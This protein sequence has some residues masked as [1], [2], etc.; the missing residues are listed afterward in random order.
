MSTKITKKQ[1]QILQFIELYLEENHTS[2]SYREI[3]SGLGLSSVSAV[4]EHVENLV[5]KGALKKVD[6]TARSLE[7]LD[8]RHTDTVNLFRNRLISS[9]PE[10]TKILLK[11]MK[12][13]GLELPEE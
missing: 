9:T 5:E 8:Y 11:A 1:L 4:A 6:G 12:L 10:E 3:A 13:L 7:V 2:P